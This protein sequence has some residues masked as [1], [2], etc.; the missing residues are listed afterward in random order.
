VVGHGGLDSIVLPA[1]TLA[2]AP[3]ALVSRLLQRALVEQL[4]DDY[5][6]TARAKGLSRAGVVVMHAMRNA[7]VPVVTVLGYV[8]V[9]LLEGAIVVELIFG[10]SGIGNLTLRAVGSADYPMIQGVVLF[11]GVVVIAFNLAVDVIYPAL[12]P[13]VR[14]G[15]AA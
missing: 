4:G 10:R 13:R 15:V 14:L 11:A 1:V 3:A 12:D 6:R 8:L 5:A 9:R 2:L 7:W